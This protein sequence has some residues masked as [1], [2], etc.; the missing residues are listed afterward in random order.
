M[1]ICIY[2]H[3]ECEKLRVRTSRGYNVCAK[4]RRARDIKRI[5]ANVKKKKNVKVLTNM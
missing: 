4:C 2:C 5:M 3:Q 1:T